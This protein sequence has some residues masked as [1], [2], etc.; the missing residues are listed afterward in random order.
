MAINERGEFVREVGGVEQ[1][2]STMARLSE[3]RAAFLVQSVHPQNLQQP[4]GVWYWK[5]ERL[6]HN[7][8]LLEEM[9]KYAHEHNVV[10]A[11][12]PF[13]QEVTNLGAFFNR[14]Q[15]SIEYSQN[16]T[17][18]PQPSLAEGSEKKRRIKEKLLG[19]E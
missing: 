9:R 18:D 14:V 17:P 11:I 13:T 7:M 16:T 12:D 2:K 6:Q 4:E 3:M 19:N 15:A 5:G 8:A 1:E 10:E